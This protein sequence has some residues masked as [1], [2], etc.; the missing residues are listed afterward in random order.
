MGNGYLAPLNKYIPFSD[1]YPKYFSQDH[2][3]DTSNLHYHEII[4]LVSLKSS[5]LLHGNPSLYRIWRIN[6]H[7]EEHSSD[8]IKR[9]LKYI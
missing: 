9:D 2:R 6:H 3:F 4:S 7:G 5:L 1:Q 8:P